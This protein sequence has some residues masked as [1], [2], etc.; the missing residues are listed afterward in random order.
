MKPDIQFY[1]RRK[2]HPLR[3]QAQDLVDSLLPNIAVPVPALGSGLDLGVLFPDPARPL[4]VEIGFGRGEHC[5][6]QAERHPDV[7]FIGCE[8]F[9]NGVAGLLMEVDARGLENVRI[10]HEDARLLLPALPEA[11]ADRVFLL[12]PDPWP[13]KR[14][15]KRRFISPENL[16]LIARVLK[17]GGEFRFA[18]DH[19]DY[20]RWGLE[21]LM[22]H[23]A[24][25]WT[26]EEAADWRNRPDDW[27]ATRYEQKALAKGDSCVYLRFRRK[28]RG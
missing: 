27:V 24:F 16:D 11:S 18:T 8:P 1:G 26:A 10:L 4:W 23:P 28:P 5:A 3:L 14:H 6:T 15:H 9:I 13:K 20:C 2:G 12:F 19:M 21:R 25:E 17:D 22:N 7:N